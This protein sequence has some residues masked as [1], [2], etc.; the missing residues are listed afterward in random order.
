[1]TFLPIVVRELRVASR[2]RS[3]YWVRS[4]AALAVLVAG[5]WM[6]LMMQNAPPRVTATTLFGLL[7]GAAVLYALVSGVRTT[8]DCVSGEK[9]EGTLGLLFLTDLKGYDVV[10]GKL[11]ANSLNAFYAVVAVVPV[12]ALPLLMGGVTPGEFGRMALVAVNTLFFSL[13]LGL[14]VSCFCRSANNSAGATLLA[15]LL[16]TALLPALG[17]TLEALGKTSRVEPLFLMPS[18]GFTYYLA[19]DSS[20]RASGMSFWYSLAAV[21]GMGWVALALASRVVPR[22]WQDKPAGAQGIRWRERWRAWTLGD[23]TERTAFRRRLLNANPFFWLASRA[24]LKPALVWVV[25]ALLGA[26]WVWGL[27]K[28]KRD[29][30]NEGMYVGTALVLNGLLRFWFANEATRQL[31]EERRAGTLELLLSTPLQ[32]REI[33]RGQML[34]LARQFLGPVLVVLL[35]EGVLMF[36]MLSATLN[37]DRGIWS[38]LWLG[39]MTMLVA[40]LVALYWLCQWQAL[41][42]RNPARAAGSS[43]AAILFLP[44]GALALVLLF[45][46]LIS[47]HG[48]PSPS[49]RPGFFVGLWFFLGVAA[50]VGFG[51]WARHKLLTQFRVVAQQRYSPAAGFWKRLLGG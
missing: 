18:P 20:Y 41:N 40:D 27:A 31:A 26:V 28:F 22:A 39:G 37:E 4:V 13:A 17:A 10:L 14:F 3:T 47:I 23:A 19:F 15:I 44:W 33:L 48:P 35:I 38:A 21:Q 34:A 43:L 49:P 45:V 7:T 46:V 16:F 36:A 32:V 51:A 11:A 42:A 25:L 50:D 30:L 29:W 2:R 24:R 8:S 1:M 9:R 12:L 6:F 5:T